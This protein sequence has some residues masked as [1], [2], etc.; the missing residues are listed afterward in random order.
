MGICGCLCGDADAYDLSI[1]DWMVWS[2]HP[3]RKQFDVVMDLGEGSFAQAM[4]GRQK[5]NHQK[6]AALKVVFLGNPELDADHLGIM[7][8]EAEFLLKLNHDS[9][10]Q[11]Y[12]V[13]DNGKQMVLLMEYLRG[14]PLLDDLHHI[15]GESYTEQQASVIAAQILEATAYMHKQGIIH[16]DLKPENIMFAQDVETNIESEDL[17]KAFNVKIIDLGM[18]AYYEPNNP[19]KG[20]LGSPGF[21]SPEIIIGGAHTYAMDVFAVGVVL[22]VLLV[23]RKPFN[24]A[25]SQSLD[26]CH[27]NLADCPGMQDPR[28]KS[29]SPDAQELV[30]GLLE[31]NP[32]KRLTAQQALQTD[33]I[34][35]I[36]GKTLRPLNPD[37]ARG[38]AN[39]AAARRLRN[40]VHGAVAL[41][42]GSPDGSQRGP[43][44]HVQEYRK[45]HTAQ[46]QRAQESRG[47]RDAPGGKGLSRVDSMALAA[48]AKSMA[49]MHDSGRVVDPGRDISIMYRPHRGYSGSHHNGGLYAAEVGGS[50]HAQQV[51]GSMHKKKSMPRNRSEGAL[52]R[53]RSLGNRT[54]PQPWKALGSGLKDY[55]D[56]SVR[57]GKAYNDSS[58]SNGSRFYDER[59]AKGGSRFY[60]DT[61]ARSGRAYYNE[62]SAKAG[63]AYYG[64]TSAHAGHVYEP[65]L[66]HDPSRQSVEGW[67]GAA[68]P[69]GGQQTQSP[70]ANGGGDSATG[71]PS[72]KVYKLTPL[73]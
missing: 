68:P 23:G 8:K 45:R 15:A 41:D 13:M 44:D 31:Y 29:L 40:M 58:G 43:Q 46:G 53:T 47:Y 70:F 71:P 30:L 73:A 33:W 48:N 28:W 21:I 67:G 59:S 9:I 34:A 17:L 57:S 6:F 4:L 7:R 64:D 3:V 62:S 39:V 24:I 35:T 5:D 66:E 36:G 56:S 65:I 38:A 10:V 12:D 63:R 49:R 20:A 16:R 42:P 14:G 27:M 26:Y 61:S 32:N 69:A 51:G 52:V 60:D 55:L 18:S 50:L 25:D 2:D 11:C 1:P 22:F 19:L 54:S 72:K 37:V